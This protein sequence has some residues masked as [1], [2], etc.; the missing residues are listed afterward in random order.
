MK[1]N[2]FFIDKHNN[3]YKTTINPSV[4]LKISPWE[5]GED[6]RVFNF[7]KKEKKFSSISFQAAMTLVNQQFA[8]YERTWE[9]NGKQYKILKSTEKGA[10]YLDSKGYFAHEIQHTLY[11]NGCIYVNDLKFYLCWFHGK[12]YWL[13]ANWSHY[14]QVQL[15]KYEDINRLPKWTEFAQWTNIKNCKVIYEINGKK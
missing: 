3:V 13:S 14:P 5:I 1:K 11:E 15:Y 8:D 10:T 12:I 2:N 6:R 4:L 7:E 9:F